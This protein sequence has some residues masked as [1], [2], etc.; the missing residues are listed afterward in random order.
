M[1][2]GP[3]DVY[4]EREGR[5]EHTDAAFRDEEELLELIQRIVAPLGRRVDQAVP[6]VDARLPD[7]SRVHAILPPLALGGP[8]LTIRKFRRHR[9]TPDDLVASGT[10]TPELARF[11]RNAVRSRCNIVIAGGT[12]SGKT[13]LLNTLAAFIPDGEERLI[14]IEDAA[15]LQLPQRHVL[16][17]EARPANVE[18]S[19]RVTVRD[20][21]RNALRMR[22]DRIII[23]EVR[24][25][26]CFDL[27]AA[28]NTGHEG[29]LT[30][31][32]ANSPTDAVDRLCNMV[33]T[34]GQGLPHAVVLQQVLRA[35]DLIVQ[36]ARLPGGQR[37]VVEVGV[38]SGGTSDWVVHPL[39]R[40]QTDGHSPP[41][42]SLVRTAVDL[43]PRLLEKAAM[44]QIRWDGEDSR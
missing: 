43:P 31:I 6:Y 7:G 5:L 30:T 34:A 28:L 20:L 13:T 2:N 42:G 27:L 40:W 18:G 39:F 32:H 29:T 33:L 36:T 21:L 3:G 22:P 8:Y 16:A 9:P 41:D 14:T 17:L 15:E 11:L 12:G 26:E 44:R 23:G 19:G 35:V 38:P 1:V 37:R 25:E 4:V 24:G 10:L